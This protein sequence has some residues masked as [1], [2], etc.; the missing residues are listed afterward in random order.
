[1]KVALVTNTFPA[2]SETFIYNHAAGLHAR[3]V[4]VTV[5]ASRRS[6]DAALFGDFDG[7]TFGGPI[8]HAVLAGSVTAT[9]GRLLARLGTLGP[10]ERQ[11]W[12]RAQDLYGITRRA[13]RAWLLA[14]PL[15]GFD[16]IHFEYSGLAIAWRDALP[17][18]APA[19]LVVSCRGAAEQI[20]P[21]FEPHRADALRDLFANVD[22][23]H[24]VS[25]DMLATCTGY[26]LDPARA[27][28]N[29]PAIDVARFQRRTPHAIRTSGPYRLLSTGRLHWKKGLEFAL[30]AVRQLVDDGHDIRL[31]IIG[32]GH[33]EEHL[34]YSVHDMRL[35]QHV[36]FAG[37]KS[38]TEVRAALEQCDVYVLPSLS[39]GLSN[40]ALEAMAMELPI[41]STTAGGMAELITDGSDGLLVRP[42][43]HVAMARAIA[44]LLRDPERRRAIGQA[45]RKRVENEF[46]LDRQIGVFVDEYAGLE[47]RAGERR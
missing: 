5:I 44:G 31:D 29:R 46:S 34:R 11:Q 18:L 21:L 4:D 13:M 23:V 39:E 28:V 35:E 30:L 17:L 7:V 19:R 32:G 10:V 8:R 2:L 42:R 27:F 12:R 14:L 3:G 38:S 20:T 22:R 43:D 15:A 26:G 25:E 41:V 37:K 16:I 1:M 9:A 36:T 6:G 24:C 47:L 45:A 40:A 33:D